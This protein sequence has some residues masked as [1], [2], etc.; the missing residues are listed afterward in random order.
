MSLGKVGHTHGFN[1]QLT[2]FF[3]V[4]SDLE[5]PSSPGWFYHHPSICP[6]T[7]PRLST[8]PPRRHL[9]FWPASSLC[10]HQTGSPTNLLPGSRLHLNPSMSSEQIFKSEGGGE[11]VLA[12]IS[13]RACLVLEFLFKVP[14][15]S[16]GFW[17]NP[18]ELGGLKN[19]SFSLNCG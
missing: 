14:C 17:S 11:S 16:W 6:A 15:A 4:L 10:M 8:I 3:P 13:I 18:R 2:R 19:W 9:S 7:P 5:I 1:R 12:I